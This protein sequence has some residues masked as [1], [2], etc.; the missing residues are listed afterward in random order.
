VAGHVFAARVLALWDFDDPAGSHA[1]FVDAAENEPDAA[2]RQ[3]MLTQ[4]ARSHGLREA[5]AAGHA[6]LDRLGDPAELADEPGTRA[7]LERGRLYHLAGDPER[8]VPL[9][10]AAYDRAVAGTLV[11]LA[12][13]AA[14]MLAIAL[15]ELAQ[16]E[17][18]TRRGLSLADGSADPLVPGMVAALLT[19]L[20]WS[21]ADEDRWTAALE[22]FDRVVQVRVASAADA[23]TLH[24]ARSD[25]ASALRAL[26]RHA[27]AL[28]ELRQMASTPEGAVD[29]YVAEEITANERALHG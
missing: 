8:A 4:V 27:E 3:A 23:H 21:Y 6:V 22:A 29:P 15:P 19:N 2:G 26:G 13:D 12:L 7:L 9:Y 24:C 16:Q 20:G 5:F 10:R 17:A 25:R 14:H 18:W 11:G 1:R 28:T